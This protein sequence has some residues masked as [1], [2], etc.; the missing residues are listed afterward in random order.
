MKPPQKWSIRWYLETNPQRENET[1][2]RDYYRRIQEIAR[3][4]G[5]EFTI[6]S[7]KVKHWGQ[8]SKFTTYHKT[9]DKNGK[10]VGRKSKVVRKNNEIDTSQYPVKRISEYTGTGAMWIIRDQKAYAPPEINDALMER[11]IPS[12]QLINKKPKKKKRDVKRILRVI[13]SDPHVGMETD[14]EAT[15]LFGFVWNAIE[16][17]K[18]KD[19]IVQRVMELYDGED[20]VHIICLGDLMDGWNKMTVRGGHELP[21]N[22]NNVEAFV[23]GGRFKVELADEIQKLTNAKCVTHNVVNDNH[24]GDFSHIVEKYAADI[25]SKVNPYVESH[26]YDKF[27]DYYQWRDKNFVLTHGKDKK[28]KKR[29]FPLVADA[30]TIKFITELLDH[31]KLYEGTTV[32]EKGD[33]HQELFQPDACKRFGYYTFRSMA[34]SSQYVQTNYGM[35]TSSFT[36]MQVSEGK[37]GIMTTSFEF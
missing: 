31:W 20:E 7:I 22:M 1:V 30:E 15:A 26:I 24:G 33:L 36:I 5:H 23:A 19:I 28:E 35:G 21:Q 8:P 34:P 6:S 14:A 29:G 3:Q 13:I 37:N 17:Q 12:I 10:L 4:N 32:I 9:Y 18:R 2:N 27:I 11:W 16:L 25:L